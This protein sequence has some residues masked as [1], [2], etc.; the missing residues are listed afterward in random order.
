MADMTVLAWCI[1][2]NVFVHA[3]SKFPFRITENVLHTYC[4]HAEH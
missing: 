3:V 1:V 4:E 2:F